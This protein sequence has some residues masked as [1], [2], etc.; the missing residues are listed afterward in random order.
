MLGQATVVAHVQGIPAAE[1]YGRLSNFPD[2]PM[3]CDAVREVTVIESD[4]EHMV[5]AWEVN[6]HRGILKW[7]ERAD[8][9]PDNGMIM[10]LSSLR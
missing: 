3:L 9:C 10:I 8:F 2:Y 4:R 6:F 7:T 5:S 1:V